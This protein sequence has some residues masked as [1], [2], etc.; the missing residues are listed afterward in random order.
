MTPDEVGLIHQSSLEVLSNLGFQIPNAEILKRF[1]DA[2]AEVDFQN[3]VAKIPPH[4]VEEALKRAPRFEESAQTDA[5]PISFSAVMSSSAYLIDYSS[6]SRR[7]GTLADVIKAIAL[8]NELPNIGMLMPLVFPEDAP[9]ERADLICQL[10]EFAYG[11]KPSG[12]WIY[13]ADSARA[14]LSMYDV[15]GDDIKGPPFYILEP[16]SPLRFP[17]HGLEITLLFGR[18][19]LPV[20]VGPMAQ[21]GFSAPITPAGTIVIQNAENLATLVMLD[22]LGGLPLLM[23]SGS[24]HAPDMRNM[25]CSF[26]SPNNIL[27]ALG[28][29]Q[30]AKFYGLSFSCNMGLTDSMTPDFQAGFEKGVQMASLLAAGGFMAGFGMQGIVGPDQGSN[31]EQLVIDDEWLGYL[32]Y[33]CNG[34]EV[35]RETIG[36]DMIFN[37]GIGGNFISER[38]TANYVRSCYWQPALFNR[39]AWEQWQSKGAKDIFSLAREKTEKILKEHFPPEQLI[40]NNK[41]SKLEDIAGYKLK[42]LI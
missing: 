21:S 31:L 36:L 12:T 32:N 13:S 1:A 11:K 22:L 26:G 42:D 6:R 15:M 4:L 20:F 14:I 41:L 28:L 33:L 19:G 7:S 38:H 8:C 37:V 3:E 25:V 34:M 18:K 17:R 30:M 23:Y 5:A 40:D 10:I 27:M 39:D 29:M 16:I 24:A 9:R 35:S 2:G